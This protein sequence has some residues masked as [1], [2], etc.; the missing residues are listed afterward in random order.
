[1]YNNHNNELL[2]KYENSKYKYKVPVPADFDLTQDELPELRKKISEYDNP[3]SIELVKY[4]GVAEQ[5]E[6]EKIEKTINTINSFVTTLTLIITILFIVYVDYSIFSKKIDFNI[7][8][9]IIGIL[10]LDGLIYFAGAD[11]V[12]PVLCS[13]FLKYPEQVLKKKK[14]EL[15]NIRKQKLD[16]LF[17]KWIS[18]RKQ[19]SDYDDA[20]KQYEFWNIITNEGY[21][22]KLNGREFEQHIES[23][24]KY[25]GFTTKLSHVGADGGIDIIVYKNNRKYAVQCKAHKEKISTSVVRDLYGVICANNFDGGYLV[26]I[27]GATKPAE[28]FC[29]SL[30]SKKITIIDIEKIL[31]VVSKKE[32]F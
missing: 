21:W 4:G 16:I 1:M 32:Q 3:S 5:E 14:K 2:I 29:G 9:E 24:Y 22:R 12:Y 8:L 27:S 25:S 11:L 15:E 26:A 18:K 7:F 30:K 10:V 17:E 23:L 31:K 19:L 20:V 28:D 13:I 6:I